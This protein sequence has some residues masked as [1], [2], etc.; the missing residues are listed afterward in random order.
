MTFKPS[1]DRS[2]TTFG[3]WK[4]SSEF[5]KDGRLYSRCIC[6]CGTEKDIYTK[7]LHN[8]KTTSCGCKRTEHDPKDAAIQYILAT[9]RSRAKRKKTSF[10]LS[11]LEFKSLILGD[12]FYCGKSG[13]CY[14]K[15]PSP[16]H[17]DEWRNKKQIEYTG[18]DRVD[19]N[20]GYSIDNCLTSCLVCNKA[21][22]TMTFNEFCSWV[23]LVHS[24]I[25][26]ITDGVK[27][28][29]KESNTTSGV[30][31]STVETSSYISKW[32]FLKE[33]TNLE[34]NKEEAK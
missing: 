25:Q 10:T 24:R 18:I 21:K 11:F 33:K 6:K 34:I 15:D 32:L 20:I 22:N 13:G 23:G 7:N 14:F 29:P 8:G 12:C 17:T 31:L 28:L 16:H 2:K 9:Y 27:S 30:H 19:S 3:Y 4:I 1:L 5:K 26:H